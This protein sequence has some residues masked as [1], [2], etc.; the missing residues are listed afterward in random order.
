MAYTVT[1]ITELVR[2]HLDLSEAD[3]DRAAGNLGQLVANIRRMDGWR[4]PLPLEWYFCDRCG[5]SVDT[6]VLAIDGSNFTP[7]GG[8]YCSDCIPG[9]LPD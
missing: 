4:E 9:R 2:H 7:D 6:D 8:F 5:A 3:P 1:D